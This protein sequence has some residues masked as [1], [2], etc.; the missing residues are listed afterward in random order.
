MID[1]SRTPEKIYSV[2]LE[3]SMNN[4]PL[5]FSMR[6]IDDVQNI[7]DFMIEYR[8]E[9]KIYEI[10]HWFSNKEDC[11]RCIDMLNKSMSQKEYTMIDYFVYRF[12]VK[13]RFVLNNKRLFQKLIYT[14]RKMNNE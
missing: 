13:R 14:I 4:K 11:Q 2:F 12:N 7:I 6:E 1:I 8:K 3:I 10:N 5:K 9:N